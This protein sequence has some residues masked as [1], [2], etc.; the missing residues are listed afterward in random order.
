MTTTT[1]RRRV[2]TDLQRQSLK[3]LLD[4]DPQP[5]HRAR[6]AGERVTLA[7]LHTRGLVERRAWR[8]DGI[9]RDS[10]FES[11]PTPSISLAYCESRADHPAYREM[12]WLDSRRAVRA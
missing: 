6:H 5:Y 8:G 12:D 3:R 1:G 9:S 11:R 7:S 4:N 10:A 2:L